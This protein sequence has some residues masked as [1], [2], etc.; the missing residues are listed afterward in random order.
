MDEHY[1]SLT[2]IIKTIDGLV[3]AMPSTFYDG[4]LKARNAIAAMPDADVMPVARGE[5]EQKE[6]FE[7]KGHVDE[8]QSAFCPYCGADMRGE[9]KHG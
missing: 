7:A 6:V 4:L 8:L 2:D 3:A 5:W 9:V 1:K